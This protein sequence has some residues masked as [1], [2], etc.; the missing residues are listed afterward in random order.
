[1]SDVSGIFHYKIKTY[2]RN[3]VRFIDWLLTRMTCYCY[4]II[5]FLEKIKNHHL[6]SR[7]VLISLYLYLACVMSNLIP[8]S[9]MKLGGYLP[10]VMISLIH[11][12][13]AYAVVTSISNPCG[14]FIPWHKLKETTNPKVLTLLI[15]NRVLPFKFHILIFFFFRKLLFR[16]H[17]HCKTFLYL[18]EGTMVLILWHDV[19]TD[20][21][22]PK[23]NTIPYENTRQYKISHWANMK[24]SQRT[25]MLVNPQ[26]GLQMLLRCW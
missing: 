20:C 14:D 25:P 24:P 4:T 6:M 10:E 5:V 11:I 2:L 22:R 9:S 12:S 15:I 18:A 3:T 19:A 7:K 13:A 21:V 1:M 8:T 17:N 16:L 23:T 26:G